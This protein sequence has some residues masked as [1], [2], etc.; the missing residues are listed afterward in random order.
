[1]NTPT[2]KELQRYITPRYA[3]SWREIGTQLELSSTRLSIIETDHPFSV[4]RCCN[5][6]LSKWLEQDKDAS[7]QK[8]FNAIDYRTGQPHGIGNYLYTT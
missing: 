4:E 2:P 6:M 3:T 8:L 5:A 1:M 7:W